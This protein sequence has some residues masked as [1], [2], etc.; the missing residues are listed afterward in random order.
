MKEYYEENGW[1]DAINEL[2]GDHNCIVED[3][4]GEWWKNTTPQTFEDENIDN[5][6][7]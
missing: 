6:P 1:Q 3:L 2:E 7:W 4:R 5:L